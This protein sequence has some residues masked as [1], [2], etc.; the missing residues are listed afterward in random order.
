MGKKYKKSYAKMRGRKYVV[1][2]RACSKICFESLKRSAYY[3][4]RLEFLIQPSSGQLKTTLSRQEASS[5][6][7]DH[8]ISCAARQPTVTAATKP[9]NGPVTDNLAAQRPH[10]RPPDC[11]QPKDLHMNFHNHTNYCISHV[12]AHCHSAVLHHILAHCH[13]HTILLHTAIPPF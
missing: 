6:E 1:Q 12:F 13:L 10:R 7:Q 4:F 2:T 8:H 11:N 5:P 9:P 3:N